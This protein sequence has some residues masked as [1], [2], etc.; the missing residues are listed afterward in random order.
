[1]NTG[2]WSDGDQLVKETA[3]A[4]EVSEIKNVVFVLGRE[5]NMLS[6]VES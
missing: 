2:K 3:R 4:S 6:D 1:M 5:V